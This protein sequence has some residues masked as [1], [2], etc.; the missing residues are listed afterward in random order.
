MRSYNKYMR[1]YFSAKNFSNKKTHVQIA[2]DTLQKFHTKATSISQNFKQ[3]QTQ[4]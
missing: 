2:K 3:N 4:I 1:A